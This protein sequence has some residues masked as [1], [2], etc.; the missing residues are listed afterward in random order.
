MAEISQIAPAEGWSAAV[1][2]LDRGEGMT[3]H[4][5]PLVCW[6]LTGVP[7]NRAV[8]GLLIPPG[9]GE[10]VPAREL[11]HQTWDLYSEEWDIR[12]TMFVGYVG[13]GQSADGHR[14]WA[15]TLY[16]QW[17]AERERDD[18][19]QKIGF[20]IAGALV[21]APDGR[22][23]DREQALEEIEGGEYAGVH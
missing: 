21:T 5:L 23:M 16:E 6:A 13:P 18:A 7:P 12:P 11:Y 10:A 9:S 1:I 3:L 22:R 2:R 20:E 4:T 19:L 17:V 8:E 15:L 14:L